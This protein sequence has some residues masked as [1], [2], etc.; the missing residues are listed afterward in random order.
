[1]RVLVGVVCGLIGL[2][3]VAAAPLT[4]AVPDRGAL[5]CDSLPHA[6]FSFGGEMGRRIDANLD[7]WLLRAPAANPGLR[8]RERIERFLRG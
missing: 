1:M 2:V 4:N 3:S 8:S 7:Q 5:H 6:S